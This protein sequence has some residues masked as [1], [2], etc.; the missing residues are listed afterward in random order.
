MTNSDPLFLLN[1]AKVFELKSTFKTITILWPR[2]SKMPT[3]RGKWKRSSY[4]RILAT[5]TRDELER[6][7]QIF[8]ETH[9]SKV[10]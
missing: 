1:G 6:C 7:F 5:Y 3:I 4:G 2:D 8:E 10:T 9:G